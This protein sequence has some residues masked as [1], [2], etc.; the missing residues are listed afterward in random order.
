M[1]SFRG[2][3]QRQVSLPV[4]EVA[5]IC[6]GFAMCRLSGSVVL[7]AWVADK[8]IV[9]HRSPKVL[10]WHRAPGDALL[11][12]IVGLPGARKRS[13]APLNIQTRT[14]ALGRP[15]SASIERNYQRLGVA[16]S[17]TLIR[18][19]FLVPAKITQSDEFQSHRSATASTE[20]DGRFHF[21][22]G[23]SQGHDCFPFQ[24]P[25]FRFDVS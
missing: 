18:L 17:R 6:R 23:P 8:S 4:G 15:V 21:T 7:A 25:T 1:V 11:S 14:W 13:G 2:W 5:R 9:P 24:M 16:T 12:A 3:L 20:D 10:T 22:R 19:H